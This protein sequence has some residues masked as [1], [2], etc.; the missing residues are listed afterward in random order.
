MKIVALI[1]AHLDEI[2][3]IE[4]RLF[5]RPLELDALQRLFDGPAF[6]GFVMTGDADL[7]S[8]QSYVFFLNAGPSADLISIG[9]V[10]EFQGAGRGAALMQAAA[11][12]LAAA[13]VEEIILEVAV[14]NMTACRLYSRLGFV[15]I[16]R[17]P[18]YYAPQNEGL[19]NKG[20]HEDRVDAIL[21]RQNLVDTFS[22]T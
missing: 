8:L 10:P 19:S 12:N 9:T 5:N 20:H 18:G 11:K 6:C 3:V 7:S 22:D 16:G 17:R 13:G 21:M 14:D 15:E 4:D 2:A 1:A